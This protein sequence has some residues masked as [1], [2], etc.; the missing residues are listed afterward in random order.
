[1]PRPLKIAF[2][3]TWYGESI[4]G[5]AEAECRGLVKGI[6]EKYPEI[7][8]EVWTT[9]L[10]EFAADWNVQFHS[11]GTYHES[12][13]LVQRF[14]VE[15]KDRTPFGP[16]NEYRLMPRIFADLQSPD[17]KLQSPLTDLEE[18]EYLSYMVECPALI[19]ELKKRQH[20][21]DFFIFMPYM[22]NLSVTGI[23][24]VQKKS[25]LIPCLHYERYAYMNLYRRAAH[26][27]GGILFH[28]PAEIRLADRL[29][30]LENA[31]YRVIGEQVE[32]KMP[33]ADPSQF[34]HKYGVNGSFLLYAGRQIAGKN[35][36]QL[37]DYFKRVKS[38][39]H[40][41]ANDLK[42]V[43]LGSGDLDYRNEH[44]DIL[45]IGHVSRQELLSAMNAASAFC[46]P[47]LN[48]SFS[49]V[50]MEAWLQKTPV[51]VHGDC[52]V[53]R[54]HIETSGGGFSYRSYHEFLNTLEPL[55]IDEQ[56]SQELAHC[57][58]S[59]V[60][61]NFTKDI[62]IERFIKFLHD[63]KKRIRGGFIS[64]HFRTKT[65]PGVGAVL[66]EI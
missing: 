20:R 63:T 41:W 31:N 7:T 61:E 32:T 65:G 26:Q 25:I 57:G 49:I 2:V 10:K 28:V 54:E 21:Y 24:V 44:P 14:P 22:F 16:M 45:Q 6:R 50:I 1:M 30:G 53:T 9:C 58:Q 43:L 5:G 18:Q 42:L 47:S 39:N 40:R 27:A 13:V 23:Q 64:K 12:E 33:Q 17:G 29:Y 56:L 4:G 62:V 38:E 3:V 36:P 19:E 8:V 37:V 51:L 46:Q 66:P 48:E 34:R 59:Y 35:L 11:P 60:L 55:I 52:D 15:P